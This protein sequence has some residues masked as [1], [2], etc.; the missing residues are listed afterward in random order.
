MRVSV[1]RES[2]PGEQRVAL[3]PE[4]AAKLQAGGFDVVV[5]RGAGV[6]AGFADEQYADRGVELAD[7]Y[8]RDDGRRR[9]SLRRLLVLVRHLPPESR[10]AQ[11]LVGTH[12]SVEAHLLDTLRMVWTHSDR[13]PAQP[14]PD[15]PTA[16]KRRQA[17]PEWQAK[18]ADARTRAR[19]RRQ[20]IESGEL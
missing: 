8:R 11:E 19:A 7:H 13:N 4:S 14:H 9:L 20:K 2:A 18:V 3:T 1:P 5:E 17:S 6:L 16:E 12:W 10:L 15:R